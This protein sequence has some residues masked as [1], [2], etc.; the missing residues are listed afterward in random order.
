MEK[1][2]VAFLI[3]MT[4]KYREWNS[5]Y[6]S[7]ILNLTFKSFIQTYTNK[8]E[9]NNY[10]IKFYLGIDKNDTLFSKETEKLE[11]ENVFKKYNQ[12]NISLDLT[13]FPE[14]IKPGHLTAMWN[15][16][17]KKA[18]DDGNHYF[19]QCGDDIQFTTSNWL[20]ECIEKLVEKNNIGVSGPNSAQWPTIVLTQSLVSRKHYEIFGYYFPESIVNWYCDN[21]ITMVYHPNYYS[22]LNHHYAPNLGGKERYNV[23]HLEH[24]YLEELEKGK[25]VLENYVMSNC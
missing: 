21:W 15:I 11:L 10:N 20:Q 7:N 25:K 19:Y 2:N 13:I 3:P 14:D 24:V 1:I 16:I 4:S 6:D 8:E 12:Y 22:K 17:F 23:A 9:E 5:V 18:Y